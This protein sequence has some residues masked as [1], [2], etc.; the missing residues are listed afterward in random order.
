M[1]AALWGA[2]VRLKPGARAR[3]AE[4]LRKREIERRLR[5]AGHSRGYAKSIAASGRRN[6]S[7]R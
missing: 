5:E 2:V 1:L 6:I 4:A 3:R 7:Q